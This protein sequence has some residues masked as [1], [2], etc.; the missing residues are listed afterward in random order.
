MVNSVE[1]S[2]V[3]LKVQVVFDALKNHAANGA[4]VIIVTH[5]LHLAEACDERVRI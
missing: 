5:S 1:N 3:S 4:T 2:L